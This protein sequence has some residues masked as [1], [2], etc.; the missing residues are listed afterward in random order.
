MANDS[1]NSH[2]LAVTANN[3]TQS[4]SYASR[5]SQ[6]A[7]EYERKWCE[8]FHCLDTSKIC[9]VTS[10]ILQSRVPNAL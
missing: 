10:S 5:A 3:D 6:Q 1:V 9:A 8:L 2:Q 7:T 4:M